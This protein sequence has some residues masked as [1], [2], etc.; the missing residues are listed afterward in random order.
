MIIKLFYSVLFTILFFFLPFRTEASCV[1][2]EDITFQDLD[3]GER[4]YNI[5]S[6]V[7]LCLTTYVVYGI[8]FKILESNIILDCGGNTFDGNMFKKNDYVSR[9]LDTADSLENVTIKNC[10]FRNYQRGLILTPAAIGITAGSYAT[11]LK[12]FN[13]SNVNIEDVHGKDSGYGEGI[14]IGPYSQDFTIE[15]STVKNTKL[16]GLYLEA[17][18]I[19]TKVINSIFIHNG[20]SGGLAGREAIAIDAS[21]ENI[22]AGNTFIDN[23]H[24]AI[25]TYKNCGES[26]NET[27]YFSLL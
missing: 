9:A 17:Y 24:A 15:N 23:K 22:I 11:G 25:T 5:K 26:K 12:K 13:I 20:F 19:R 6:D 7:E 21:S 18:S 14:V 2:L 3:S 4:L 10:N 27:C 16:S 8:R 1:T